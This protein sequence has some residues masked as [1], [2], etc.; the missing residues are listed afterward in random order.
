MTAS[1]VAEG[2]GLRVERLSHARPTPM[3]TRHRQ[4][5]GIVMVTVVDEREGTGTS[6]AKDMAEELD[7][8]E[9]CSADPALRVPASQLPSQSCGTYLVGGTALRRGTVLGR[10]G[11]GFTLR[12]RARSGQRG[13]RQAHPQS[14]AVTG[15]R[16]WKF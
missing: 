2:L 16:L 6:R 12:P 13:A 3:A 7:L 14:R 11:D 4:S 1:Q 15:V 5:S 10:G 9:E 8:V